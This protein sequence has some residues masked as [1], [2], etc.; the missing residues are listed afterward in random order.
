MSNSLA[1]IFFCR[2]IKPGP[3]RLEKNYRLKRTLDPH[4]TLSYLPLLLLYLCFLLTLETPSSSCFGFLFGSVSK[5]AFDSSSCVAGCV[6]FLYIVPLRSEPFS[7]FLSV[8]V[9]RW[10]VPSRHV[11]VGSIGQFR[12]RCVLMS[13]AA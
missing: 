13:K 6:A 2:D 12:F 7:F 4:L 5:D 11:Y 8:L 1:H 3:R 9:L 10:H